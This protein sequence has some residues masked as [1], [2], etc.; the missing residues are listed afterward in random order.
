MSLCSSA[1]HVLIVGE[2][3]STAG[4]E[5]RGLPWGGVWLVLPGLEGGV[6][7]VL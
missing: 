6:P 7:L 3:E 5:K 2:A 1:I 4:K